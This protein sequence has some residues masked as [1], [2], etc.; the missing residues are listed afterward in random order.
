ML[1]MAELKYSIFDPTGNIT[2]L[3]E[4]E[5]DAAE[6]PDVSA[7]IMSQHPEVEQVGFVRFGADDG[8]DVSL[9]MAG[10]EFCGNATMSA[11]AL[12]SIRSGMAKLSDRSGSV[13]EPEEIL[14]KASGVSG[15]IPVRLRRRGA[16]EF[17]AAVLMPAA[18]SIEKRKLECH[19]DWM[20]TSGDET[21]V[22]MQGIDHIVVTHYSSL[23]S[24]RG[25]KEIAGA[26]IRDLCGQLGSDCLGL[27]FLYSDGFDHVMTPLVY[28][29][30]VD[31]VFWENSCA[32]GTAAAGMYLAAQKGSR[33]D[34]N[35]SEPAGILRV[36]S[37]PGTGETWLHGT[38]KLIRNS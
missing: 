4:T 26:G 20:R 5:V 21:I 25:L 33:I 2:A 6:Q 38:T 3:V 37:D 15:H 19:A 32:S 13:F 34:I 35:V 10:G 31:T 29:P 9:R 23:Y 27:M 8:A 12:C 18:I 36:T 22:H 30:G 24:L 14:V 11:A 1:D 16:A 28:V 7:Q 17:D